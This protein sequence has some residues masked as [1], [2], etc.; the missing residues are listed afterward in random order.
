M[1]QG[2]NNT[3]TEEK[4]PIQTKEK[5]EKKKEEKR[6]SSNIQEQI[7]KFTA[8]ESGLKKDEKEN[9][10]ESNK[11]EEN[12]KQKEDTKN[13]IAERIKMMQGGSNTKK[14]EKKEPPKKLN[15]LND[16]IKAFNEQPKKEEKKTS[17]VV[18]NSDT[19]KKI[20]NKID[21]SKFGG[22]FASKLSQMN[23]MFKNQGA[24]PALRHRYSLVPKHGKY[25]I[26]KEPSGELKNKESSNLGIITEEPDKSKEGY[27]PSTNLQKTLD[28]V[29]VK[30]NKKK[31]KPPTFSG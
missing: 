31:K 6:K 7:R 23:E 8:P 1:F 20:P 24:D 25:N 2:N 16:R 22:D 14:D 26:N 3:K 21:T 15:S 11:N 10:K 18:Q 5:D 30:K 13:K 29:V 12:T 17:Q 19:L 4:K 28:A 9:K 27:D